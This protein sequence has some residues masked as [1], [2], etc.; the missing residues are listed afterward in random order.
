M[1]ME[2]D[3]KKVKCCHRS[4]GLLMKGYLCMALLGIG[5]NAV[6][7]N[8]SDTVPINVTGAIYASSCTVTFPGDIDLGTYYRQNI[9]VAGAHTPE[10]MVTV[11]LTGCSPFISKATASFS[12]TPYAEDTG[13]GAYLYANNI[14]DG[15]H[16]LGLQLFNNDLTVSL[17]NNT[18][19]MVNIDGTTQSA[20]LV[21]A[22]RLY[23]PHGTPTA[24]DFSATVTINFTYN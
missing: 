22:A 5:F 24:G 8:A 12:G 17:G 16:D 14:A 2:M 9:S 6:A 10:V 1:M 18:S 15:A 4:Q 20:S 21:M 7:Y 19:Y 3:S 23:T 13:F 11:N